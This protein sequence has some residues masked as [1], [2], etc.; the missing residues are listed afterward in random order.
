LDPNVETFGRVVGILRQQQ[1]HY[2]GS[3]IDLSDY[4]KLNIDHLADEMNLICDSIKSSSH[5][6][7]PFE[8]DEN[9][10]LVENSDVMIFIP[11]DAKIPPI[12]I[13]SRRREELLNQRILVCI[14]NWP[15][16]SIF[17]CGHFVKSLGA[18]GDKAVETQ[19]LLHEFG[20]S[21]EAFTNEVMA[22]LPGADWVIS[23]DIIAQRT[24]L[25]HIPVVSIDP[26][27][28]KCH[29]VCARCQLFIFCRAILIYSYSAFYL[30]L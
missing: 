5:F 23:E 21:H 4:S 25:R 20:V 28:I 13:K 8:T 16:H 11:V 1:K 26:P 2:A 18:N 12:F 3:V 19:V 10:S 15:I 6:N 7:T 30:I 17:P 22:C 9:V 29:S 27:G 24:D 14:D